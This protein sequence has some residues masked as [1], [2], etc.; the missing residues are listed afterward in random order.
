[1]RDRDGH[2]DPLPHALG[3]DA[4]LL[5]ELLAALELCAIGV[6][7]FGH[8]LID[9]NWGGDIQQH[10]VAMGV[11]DG[12]GNSAVKTGKDLGHMASSVWHGISSIF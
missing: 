11:V 4:E 9:E 5:E 12:V 8:N 2:R 7:D 3:D 6:G 10:G 1:M